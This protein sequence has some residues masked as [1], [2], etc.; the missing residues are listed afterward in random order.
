MELTRQVILWGPLAA[1]IF[2]TSRRLRSWWEYGEIEA[3]VRS[4]ARRVEGKA[5]DPLA[6][7]GPL[8]PHE[9]DRRLG[10]RTHPGVF[11]DTLPWTL[12]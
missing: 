1:V 4:S 5:A 8:S 10:E 11:S 2:L 6:R 7:V 3:I 9:P 12:G